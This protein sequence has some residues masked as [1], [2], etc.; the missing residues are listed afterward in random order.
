[1]H[2]QVLASRR[3][4]CQQRRR[5]CVTECAVPIDWQW[6]LYKSNKKKKKET[7]AFTK[8]HLYCAL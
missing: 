6:R 2:G 8:R 1:M 3:R 5:P 4:C 7:Q